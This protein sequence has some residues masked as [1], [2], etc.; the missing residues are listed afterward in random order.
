MEL[1]ELKSAWHQTQAELDRQKKM[2]SSLLAER[3]NT[4]V[5]ASLKP[6]FNWQFLQIVIG[7]VLAVA[8]ARFW[9]SR[10]DEPLLL[11]SGLIVHAYGIALVINGAWVIS[12]IR[13]I[14]YCESVTNIQK[15][16]ARLE[17]SYVIS[18]WVLGLPWWLLWIPTSLILVTWFGFDVAGETLSNWII[19]NTMLGTIGMVLT[20]LAYQ[21]VRRST[22]PGVRERLDRVARGV[23][24]DGAKRALA[25]IERFEDPAT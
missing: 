11:A 15:R 10:M 19:A 4:R 16:I 23:S 21:W 5:E 6:L 12:R 8:G 1:D 22:R 25:D 2:T 20:V 7:A 9:F 14:D 24:I 13:E 3:A 17:Q 18:G